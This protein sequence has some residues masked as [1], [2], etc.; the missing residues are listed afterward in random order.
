MDKFKFLK[1]SEIS[2]LPKT[3]GVYAFYS[4]KRLLYIGKGGN[5]RERVRNH[6]HQPSYRDHLFIDKVRKVGYI[7]TDS[8]IEA[9]IL[10]AELIKKHQP[11]YNVAWK[12]DKNYFY[13]V[14]TKEN[15]PRVFIT[16][17]PKKSQNKI[18]EGSTSVIGPFVDGSSLKQTLKTLRKVFPYRT[19]NPPAG[20]LPKKPCLWYQLDR[21]P[22][23][24]LFK[25]N[26]GKQI[27]GDGAS[28]KLKREYLRNVN[29]LMG[30]LNGK[31]RQV[32]K[33]MAKEMRRLA[34]EQKFEKAGK[35]KNQIQAL[36]RVLSHARIF[37][38]KEVKPPS[39]EDWPY[40]RVEAYD[41]ANIQGAAA[42]GAM[43]VFRNGKPD[44]SQYRKFKIRGG[45]K[46]NDIAM[47]KEVLSRRLKHKEW[48]YP[49]LILIDGGKAQLNAAKEVCSRSHLEHIKVMAIAK[50]NNELY[51]DEKKAP[52]LLKNTPREFSNTILK[53][54]DEA[55]RFAQKYHHKLREDIFR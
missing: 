23:P 2:R 44:K 9:L 20:G 15:F 8:E 54:R 26:L 47:I 12:D 25:S 39:L 7:K 31:K 27:V 19:C 11:D 51:S 28:N 22:A 29:N 32:L 24:C 49:D 50:K 38:M 13:V 46:P 53:L 40:E 42:T 41:I 52:V 17:Q 43:V 34:K 3:A 36:Q 35:I 33:K 4:G 48:L 30:V 18:D 21:C 6:F 45:N 37:D 1:K 55:H 5:I 14:A 16:H 10:E